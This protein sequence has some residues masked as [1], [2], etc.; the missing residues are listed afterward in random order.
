MADEIA[1]SPEMVVHLALELWR[2]TLVGNPVPCIRALGDRMRHPRP[3]DLVVSRTG[4]TTPAVR[5]VGVLEKKTREPV[6]PWNDPDEPAPLEEVW[7]IRT[8]EGQTR[9]VNEDFVAVPPLNRKERGA[10]GWPE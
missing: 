7:Y 5:R 6:E 3:G 10:Q 8:D 2:S 1:C 4:F 9:W